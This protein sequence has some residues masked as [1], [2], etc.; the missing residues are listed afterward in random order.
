MR[1]SSLRFCCMARACVVFA[2]EGHC[3]ESTRD[4]GS[5]ALPSRRLTRVGG[6][7]LGLRV[8]AASVH[9]P[10]FRVKLQ[11][12]SV[13][14]LLDPESGPEPRRPWPPGPCP[15]LAAAAGI[16]GLGAL[17]VTR[18]TASRP[19]KGTVGAGP[20]HDAPAQ[21]RSARGPSHISSNVFNPKILVAVGRAG[22][23][24]Q[25]PSHISRGPGDLAPISPP[26]V[27]CIRQEVFACHF[28][29]KQTNAYI[30]SRRDVFRH[31]TDACPCSRD[32]SHRFGLNCV[33]SAF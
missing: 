13:R 10:E 24:A 29:Q 15:A 18:S 11:C 23:L 25:R 28:P 1:L 30:G 20:A 3:S 26:L 6:G 14:V 8:G 19:R 16:A 21:S 31:A 22:R 4:G 27:G 5:S 32:R 9:W 17:G 2:R 12:R 7:P 33:E